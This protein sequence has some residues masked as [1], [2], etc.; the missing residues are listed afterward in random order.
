M[1]ILTKRGN[2]DNVITYE[3]ICDTTEDMAF[4]ERK[5]ITLGSTC[6]VLQGEGG[7]MEVYMADSNKE[8]HDIMVTG[9]NEAT[10]AGLELHVCTSA[11]VQNGKP[12]IDTPLE[13]TLYLV[14][15]GA[16][17]GN[18]YDEYVYV[19]EQWELFGGAR[20]SLDGYATESWVQQQNYLTRV[21]H[22]TET[23]YGT[24]KLGTGLAQLVDAQGNDEGIGVL[25]AP[26]SIIKQGTETDWAVPVSGA[27]TAAFYGL[28]KAAGDTT[29]AQSSNAIGTYT[30][31]AKTAI[32]GM[33]DVP[34]NS[35]IPTKVS[36]LT[37]DSGFITGYTETDPTV[38]AWAKAASKPT[39][40]A[41]EVGA[42]TTQEM[43]SAIATAIG[44]SPIESGTG[45]GSIQTK[46]YT[47]NNDVTVHTQSA[48]GDGSMAIGI[49]TFTSGMGAFAEGEKTVALAEGAHAEGCYTAAAG[50]GAAHAEGYGT[51]FH[52]TV[53][54][55]PE[56]YVYVLDLHGHL[57]SSVKWGMIAEWNGQYAEI[58][59]V[60]VANN[61]I[62]IYKNWDNVGVGDTINIYLSTASGWASHIE[63]VDT[64]ARYDGPTHAEG[65]GAAALAE[66]AHAEG[67]ATVASG[68]HS[69]AEGSATIADSDSQHVSGKFNIV[70]SD[71]TYAEIV[72][73]GTDASTRSNA[74]TLDWNGNA[75]Y[76]GKVTAGGTPTNAND[77]T[78]KQYVD[79]AINGST[80]SV[81]GTT[82]TV[83][84]DANTMYI[85]GEV[86]TLSFT[87]AA[88]GISDIIF[89]SGSTATVLTIPN[90]VKF[91]DWFDA[92]ALE[93]N[94]VYEISIMNGTYGAV[95]A[96]ATT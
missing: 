51:I 82:P 3:H 28:A 77:L 68:T 34:S 93:P 45:V 78:T 79:N 32:R 18:L 35:A 50:E 42:P 53:T 8:W 37:N 73:N 46:Q 61:S 14:P 52:A 74:R 87:P 54:S 38:P 91:P 9:G 59:D 92:T 27:G 44:N 76:A 85:C 47:F 41:A 95:M 71:D 33:L 31:A 48:T 63:G 72:G 84:A 39:Y 26:N 15:S 58:G 65:L 49:D 83:T 60:D 20:V 22:A 16:E 75:W 55:K 36:D 89:E 10:P 56:D 23:D 21:P 6:V 40:T 19:N 25:L 86:S 57:L 43:N 7:G 96:W 70:D 2:L 29:Q 4:I 94:M 13:S 11:E 80:V 66:A 67:W 12:K 64:F 90:T 30:D 88:T 24:I 5:Y 62:S 81:S 1:H 69:H 17:S